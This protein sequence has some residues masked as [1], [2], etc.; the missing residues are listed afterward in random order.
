MFNVGRAFHQ[1]GV[2]H[3]ACHF[4]HQVLVLE[5]END[6][7]EVGVLF[8]CHGNITLYIHGNGFPP[9]CSGDWLVTFDPRQ[10]SISLLS[11]EPVGTMLWP[12]LH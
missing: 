4:Y 2:V 5:P 6:D 10:P 3:A 11:T 8:C 9:N 12:Q 7:I 1:I